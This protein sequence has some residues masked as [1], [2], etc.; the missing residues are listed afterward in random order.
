MSAKGKPKSNIAPFRDKK[1]AKALELLRKSFNL[2]K[3]AAVIKRGSSDSTYELKLEDGS[4]IVLGSAYEVHQQ[5][6]VQAK[7]FDAKAR[8][9]K[10]DA[11]A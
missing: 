11:R 8:M 4:F 2:S 6:K 9:P 1:K 10:H 7:L 3:L 5:A